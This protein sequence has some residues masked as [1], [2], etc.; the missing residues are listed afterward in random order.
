DAPDVPAGVE[1]TATRGEVA[2]FDA[3]DDRLP[4][5]CLLAGL[6]DCEASVAAGFRQRVPDAHA[7]PPL[8]FLKTLCFLITML[9]RAVT[10]HNFAVTKR[11]FPRRVVARHQHAVPRG[12]T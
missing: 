8:C 11:A 2:A 10:K 6:G 12:G 5:A 1:I 7:A 9:S 3:A 4:D